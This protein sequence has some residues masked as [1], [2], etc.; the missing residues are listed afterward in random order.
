[1]STLSVLSECCFIGSRSNKKFWPAEK[2]EE[3]ERKGFEGE[4][5]F[6]IAKGRASKELLFMCRN[7]LRYRRNDQPQLLAHIFSTHS[8]Q[9]KTQDPF[10]RV[11]ARNYL[12]LLYQW[13]PMKLAI[14]H[15][16][17]KLRIKCEPVVSVSWSC[18]QGGCW[19]PPGRC[20]GHVTSSGWAPGSE[21]DPTGRV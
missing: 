1:M 7:L 21:R 8:W 19:P 20:A 4:G 9:P 16:I 3:L 6:R 18:C 14:F 5:F 13:T 2:R 17:F 11:Q 15:V 12:L 10:K